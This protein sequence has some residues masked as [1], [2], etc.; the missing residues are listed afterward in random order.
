MAML[1]RYSTMRCANVNAIRGCHLFRPFFVLFRPLDP[2]AIGC[3][4]SA[5]IPIEQFPFLRGRCA[6]WSLD[7]VAAAANALGYVNLKIA[8][9]KPQAV[10]AR[11]L[12]PI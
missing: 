5:P 2:L 6:N 12:H 8:L 10:A 9:A 4:D 7:G 1:T 3:D 11:S